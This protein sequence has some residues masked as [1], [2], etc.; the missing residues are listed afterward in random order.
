MEFLSH[1][2]RIFAV[3]GTLEFLTIIFSNWLSFLRSLSSPEPSP[4][5]TTFLAGQAELKSRRSNSY[6]WRMSIALSMKL[7]SQPNSCTPKGLSWALVESIDWVFLLLWPRERAL[8]IS[9]KAK[10]HPN[11]RLSR[12]KGRSLI[13][14]MGESII[15]EGNFR[16]PILS[17]EAF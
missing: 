13:P 11:L 1:P 9:T 2:A 5:R 3:T 14:A 4:R 8:I 7:G 16:F 6:F 17:I 10:E 12:R 15:L